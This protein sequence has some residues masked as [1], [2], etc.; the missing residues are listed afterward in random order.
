MVCL[1]CPRD[2]KQL[3][4]EEGSGRKEGWVVF[5]SCDIKASCHLFVLLLEHKLG[6]RWDCSYAVLGNWYEMSCN[7]GKCW[8][9]GQKSIWHLMGLVETGEL[10]GS[11]SSQEM[12]LMQPE[13]RVSEGRGT[14]GDQG[15]QDT[16][17]FATMVGLSSFSRKTEKPFCSLLRILFTNASM[18]LITWKTFLYLCFTVHALCVCSIPLLLFWIANYLLN[19]H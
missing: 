9:R 6:N 4:Y 10:S 18:C 17:G 1:G 16:S 15:K 13:L 14:A 2:L 8:R 11:L 5:F 12:H 7:A 3:S 19:F